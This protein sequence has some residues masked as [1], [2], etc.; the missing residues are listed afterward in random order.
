MFESYLCEDMLNEAPYAPPFNDI[1]E[2]LMFITTY[3]EMLYK[4]MS[5]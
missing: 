4:D 3:R 1:E 5:D 2:M